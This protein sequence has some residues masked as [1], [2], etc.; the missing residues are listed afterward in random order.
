SMRSIVETVKN[1]L[2]IAVIAVVAYI[3]IRGKF[4]EFMKLSDTGPGAIWVF[5]MTTAFTIVWRIILVLIFLALLDLIYQRY[6]HEQKLKMTKE[7][8][9]EER[10]QMEGDP[11]IKSRIKSLQREMARRRMM[12][13]VPKATVVVTNPTHIAIAIKYEPQEMPTPKVLAKGKRII[14]EKIKKRALEH[15]IPVVEDKPL[16]RAMYDKV[17]EGEDI[18][19]EFFTAVAEILAYVYRLKNKVAA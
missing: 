3:T 6:E 5:F 11:Q 12:Q 19:L 7:E 15:D 10:K 14:A 4:F 17:Q 8:I 18:P 2:K 13:E 9:K 1:L 16:A